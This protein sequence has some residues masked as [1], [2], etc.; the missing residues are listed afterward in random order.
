MDLKQHLM[1]TAVV[2]ASYAGAAYLV[3]PLKPI[4]AAAAG[5]MYSMGCKVVR[6]TTDFVIKNKEAGAAPTVK[7]LAYAVRGV[8]M[9]AL[10][11]GSFYVAADYAGI[12]VTFKAVAIAYGTGFVLSMA[13]QSILLKIKPDLFKQKI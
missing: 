10:G 11:I 1:T 5:F 13:M 8:A 7:N 3:G 9:I 6:Y 2:T 4:E 12:A